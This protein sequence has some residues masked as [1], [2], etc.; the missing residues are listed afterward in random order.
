[1]DHNDFIK[2]IMHM[3][4]SALMEATENS[5]RAVNFGAL[6]FKDSKGRDRTLKLHVIVEPEM[7]LRTKY[8]EY[9]HVVGD[10]EV[11][12]HQIEMMKKSSTISQLKMLEAH[13]DS[14]NIRH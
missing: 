9:T 13:D 1:M 14:D 7:F 3:V 2:S 8:P 10:N 12:D 6:G 4:D 11:D 5:V